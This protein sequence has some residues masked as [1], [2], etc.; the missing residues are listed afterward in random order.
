MKTELPVLLL[1]PYPYVIKY[2]SSVLPLF[3][4]VFPTRQ[5]RNS[6]VEPASLSSPSLNETTDSTNRG[7]AGNGFPQI[8]HH[9]LNQ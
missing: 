5:Y 4:A 7:C 2:V 3:Q 8:E 9:F 1:Y 6:W